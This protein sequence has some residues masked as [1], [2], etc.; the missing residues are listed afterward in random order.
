MDRSLRG[1]FWVLVVLTCTLLA[2]HFF[3]RSISW[4]VHERFDLDAEANIP[5]W[6]ATVL[7]FSVAL[8]A[9]LIFFVER[10]RVIQR[11][12]WRYFWLAFSAI[13]LFISLDEAARLHEI[14]DR[15]IPPK[16]VV[17]YA[18]F[19]VVFF[20]VSAYYLTAI[21]R[22]LSVRSWILGGL[23]VYAA[24][25]LAAEAISHALFPLPTTLQQVEF[26]VE[27]GLEL[28][29]TI[30]VLMGCLLELQLN[31]RLLFNSKRN[32]P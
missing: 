27:E 30:G 4:S 11:S 17:I 29:G 10:A 20:M 16:W 15:A 19:F 12:L 18:P 25:A 23:I 13:Y 22:D 3:P 31:H 9:S 32:S 14:L 26:V 7:L 21:H 6:Y 28:L 1:L 2:L 24:G 5:T 8:C